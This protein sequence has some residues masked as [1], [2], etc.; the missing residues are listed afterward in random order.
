VIGVIQL[1]SGLGFIGIDE[2]GLYF[3]V[4]QKLSNVHSFFQECADTSHDDFSLLFSQGVPLNHALFLKEKDTLDTDGGPTA[5]NLLAHEHADQLVIAATAGNR[6]HLGLVLFAADR[7]DL[8]NEASIV[9]ESSGQREIQ[10]DAGNL[11]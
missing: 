10:T 7:D 3:V 11:S 8:Q 2:L 1:L 4:P 5:A 9:I 6:A